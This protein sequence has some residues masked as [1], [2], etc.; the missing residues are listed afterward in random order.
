M[1][2]I[3]RIYHLLKARNVLCMALCNVAFILS[4]SVSAGAQTEATRPLIQQMQIIFHLQPYAA[5]IDLARLLI[6]SNSLNA[7][8]QDMRNNVAHNKSEVTFGTL[9]LLQNLI[10]QYRFSQIFFGWQEPDSNSS[11]NIVTNETKESLKQL[12][13]LS[14]DLVTEYGFDDSPYTQITANTFKQMHQL[15]NGLVHMNIDPLLKTALGALVLPFAEAIAAATQGDR[16]KTFEKA[17]PLVLE[18]RKLYPLFDRIAMT[19][20]GFGQILEIQG[21]NEFYAEYGQLT[22]EN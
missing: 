11:A 21:L 9:R 12:K 1:K 8:V 6:I 22:G 15:I 19:Q 20:A 3:H 18:I 13:I 17:L 7:V 5:R 4:I 16:P 2:T 10:I 14:D